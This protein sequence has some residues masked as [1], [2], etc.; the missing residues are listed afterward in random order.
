MIIYLDESKKLWEGQIV[1]WWFITKH[2]VSYINKFIENKKIEYWFNKTQIELK[3]IQKGWK[4]FY[5][6]MITDSRFD[7]ISNNIIWVSINWYFSD[8]K[9]KYI[10]ILCILIWKIFNWIKIIIK[11]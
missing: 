8:N 11:I 9:D 7:I 6:R 5:D 3:S 1:F 4:I 2:T 10:E